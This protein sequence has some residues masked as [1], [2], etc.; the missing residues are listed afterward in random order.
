LVD[1]HRSLVEV[2]TFL[3]SCQDFRL[4]LLQQLVLQVEIESGR[5]LSLLQTDFS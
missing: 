4:Q 2:E 1:A 5:G 3:N